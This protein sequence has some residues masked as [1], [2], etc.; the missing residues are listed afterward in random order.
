MLPSSVAVVSDAVL[1]RR[2]TM[3]VT[4]RSCCGVDVHQAVVVA[5]VIVQ[6]GRRKRQRKEVRSFSTVASGLKE[7]A[8]WIQSMGCTCVAMESTGV[9]WMPVYEMLEGVVPN[10]IVANARHIKNVPGRKTDVCDSMWICELA[11]HGLLKPGFVPPRPIRQ[12]RELTRQRHRLVQSAATERNRLIKVLER[13]G[14]KLSTFL[15][16]VFGVSGRQIILALIAGKATP[17]QMAQLAKGTLKKKAADIQQALEAPLDDAARFVL[18][19]QYE[20]VVA[21]EKRIAALDD[22]IDKNLKPHEEAQKRLES[23]VGVGAV[24]FAA[25]IGEIGTDLSSFPNQRAFSSWC[26]LSP[27]NNMS[28][29]KRANSPTNLGNCFLRSLLVECAWAAIKSPGYLKTKYYKLKSRRGAKRAIVA[30]AHKLAI[31]VYQVLRQKTEYKE[32]PVEHLE[33]A[34][35]QHLEKAARKLSAN[36]YVVL[37]PTVPAEPEPKAELTA[38]KRS[39]KYKRKAI[40]TDP[41]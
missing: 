24:S 32:L 7:M 5:C 41:D 16:D 1:T 29:G 19:S 26:G 15:S 17:E 21:T 36:G 4:H 13:H 30:I 31:A 27:G 34:K 2:L 9:Y 23:I 37:K 3:D 33:R 40:R 12:L 38:P 22:E 14:V 35:K 8:Q 18:K 20:H 11:R 6:D 39:K 28:A 10:V 25:I